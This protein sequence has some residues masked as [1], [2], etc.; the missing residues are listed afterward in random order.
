MTNLTVSETPEK[1][2][3]SPKI[4]RVARSKSAHGTAMEILSDLLGSQPAP[5]EPSHTH[6]KPPIFLALQGG[7]AK[8]IVHVGAATAISDLDFEIKG[9]SGTSA[10]SIVAALLAAGYSPKELFDLDGDGNLFQNMPPELKVKKP[11][12]LFPFWGWVTLWLMRETLNVP[13]RIRTLFRKI[14]RRKD[15]KH[16]GPSGQLKPVQVAQHSPTTVLIS[17]VSVTVAAPLSAAHALPWLQKLTPDQSVVALS[18]LI[19]GAAAAVA[20]IRQVKKG[21]TNVKKV[22]HFINAAIENKIPAKNKELGLTFAELD[23]AQRPPLK[24]VATNVYEQKL[25]LFCLD[26]TPGVAIADAVAASICLPVIFKTWPISFWRQRP[27]MDPIAVNS[28]FQD[29]GLVSNL[30]AWPFDAERERSAE[31]ATVALSIGGPVEPTPKHWLS[32]LAGTVVNGNME[33]HTRATGRFSHI[34][35]KTK[36]DMLDFDAPIKKLHAEAVGARATAQAQLIDDLYVIPMLL[37]RFVGATHQAILEILINKM[38]DWALMDPLGAKLRVS[39]AVESLETQGK[40][41]IEARAGFEAEDANT[42][43]MLPTAHPAYRSL[44]HGETS[45]I[46]SRFSPSSLQLKGLWHEAKFVICLPLSASELV[47]E[48]MPSKPV[49]CVLI[50]ESNIPVTTEHTHTRSAYNKCIAS[51]KAALVDLECGVTLNKKI[52]L[53]DFVQRV[54]TWQ[55]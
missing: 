10:G 14:L 25:E 20:L 51:I 50:L 55:P 39:L 4:A 44:V 37:H 52:K 38:A 36:L 12:D 28:V 42:D 46:L 15:S 33:V 11:T 49:G 40:F 5:V 27:G 24:I 2:P 34:A 41:I 18:L 13:K 26:R 31:I 30:P 7:G 19:L 23:A 47:I 48:S 53:A 32:A 17:I 21:I 45:Q 6:H 54:K 16:S 3:E 9:Y 35:L 1:P 29:G 22:R 8:G 43:A